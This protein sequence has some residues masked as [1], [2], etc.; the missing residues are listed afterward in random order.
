[1]T[2]A[3]LAVETGGTKVLARLFG[4][5][6]C[7]EIR[8]PTTTP[9]ATAGAIVAFVADRL[10]ASYRL[11]AA[12]LAA[13]GPLVLKGPEA[14]RILSTPKPGWAGSNLRAALADRLGCP[15]AIDTDV[16]AAAR[17]ELAAGAAAGLPSAAYVTIGTGI[18]A[19]LAWGNSTLR[20]ALHPEIGH[21]RLVRAEGDDMHSV[22]PY[23]RDCA[24][25]LASG[26]ALQHR[27]GEARL[28]ERPDVQGFTAGYIAQLLAALVLAWS[29]HRI[30]LGGGVGSSGGMID[31]V[32]LAYRRELGSY[33]V[34]ESAR[35]MQFILPAALIDA[36]LEGAALLAQSYSDREDTHYV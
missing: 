36:G 4:E 12:G 35:D 14:G 7:R 31:A 2:Y 22:C 21:L 25:G 15:V 32:R 5:G 3:F 9:D 10:P 6:L 17:A 20:G 33:G 26:P 24:E 34:G 29:P 13:F 1:M 19:G 8:W 30:V 23:H 16:N 28:A 27:L 11:A 18:G